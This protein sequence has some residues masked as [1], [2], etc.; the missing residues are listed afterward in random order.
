MAPTHLALAILPELRARRQAGARSRVRRRL[1]RG[2]D[3]PHVEPAFP[4]SWD[5]IEEILKDC[6]EEENTKIAG[7]NAARIY[8]SKKFLRLLS[9]L[10]LRPLGPLGEENPVLY[11]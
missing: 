2:S 7:G 8:V 6:T 11:E 10:T 5:I 9:R 4:R 3:Y 1:L